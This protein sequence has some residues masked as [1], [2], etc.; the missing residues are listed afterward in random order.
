MRFF[1]I[2]FCL[3]VVL[4]LPQASIAAR[5]FCEDAK[6]SADLVQCLNKE[7]EH[8]QVSLLTT[9]DTVLQ[10][11]DEAAAS[12][13]R[14]AQR[15][16]VI[17]RNSTCLWEAAKQDNESL[18]RTRELSCLIRI[19]EHRETVLS[20]AGATI[21]EQR[22]NQGLAPLWANVLSANYPEVYWRPLLLEP[23]DMNCNGKNEF[24]LTGIQ[25]TDSEADAG[26]TSHNMVVG[27]A[28]MAETGKPKTTLFS[29]PVR[30][31]IE[32]DQTAGEANIGDQENGLCDSSL[33]LSFSA[34]DQAV[35]AE[36]KAED[37]AEV[38]E[39]DICVPVGLK[40]ENSC[41]SYM[42]RW[43]KDRDYVLNRPKVQD[44]EGQ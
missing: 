44:I 8:K 29:F 14:E 21:A 26:G 33:S 16:W 3:F 7:Y 1:S 2:F 22:E 32:D 31:V 9:F 20:L 40:I 5:A 36:I 4:V 35:T 25:V 24:I 39:A 30:G 28:S 6:S 42:V 13:L 19:T 10:N 18:R 11:Q 37:I 23:K 27:I 41:A 17:Y 15:D 12:L 38:S 34:L 43:D